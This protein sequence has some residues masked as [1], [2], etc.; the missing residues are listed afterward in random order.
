MRRETLEGAGV[1]LANQYSDQGLELLHEHAEFTDGSVS[2]EAGL[3]D[4]P[5]RMQT[6]RFKVFKHLN[7]WWEEFRLYHRK[8]GNHDVALCPHGKGAAQLSPRDRISIN[9]AFLMSKPFETVFVTMRAPRFGDHVGVVEEGHFR[10]VDDVV[11]LVDI[12]GVQRFDKKGK[13]IC[14]QLKPG[15]DARKVAYNLTRDNIPNRSG[16]FNRKIIYPNVGKF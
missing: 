6:G 8:D 11:T 5:D 7:D 1:A 12:N 3:M 15:E 2:V 13:P 9:G 14:H 4:M 16:D 10:T